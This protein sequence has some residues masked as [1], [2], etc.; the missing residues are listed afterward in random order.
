MGTANGKKI[1]NQNQYNCLTHD[2]LYLLNDYYHVE[3]KLT[4]VKLLR[5]INTWFLSSTNGESFNCSKLWVE[6]KLTSRWAKL[7][8]KTFFFLSDTKLIIC[9]INLASRV[10]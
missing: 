9:V 4:K 10:N 3:N 5:K 6:S 8:W 7:D 1:E 2:Y